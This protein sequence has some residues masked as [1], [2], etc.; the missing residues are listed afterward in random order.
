MSTSIP[1]SKKVE[2][3]K[4]SRTVNRLRG[5]QT[6]AFL[7]TACAIAGFASV[8]SAVTTTLDFGDSTI[9]VQAAPVDSTAYFAA[10]GVSLVNVTPGARVF[11]ADDRWIYG[12][13]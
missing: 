4:F 11:I 10:N 6:K 2:L 1:C 3:T 12:G 5:T 7:A 9:N 8:A 13:G